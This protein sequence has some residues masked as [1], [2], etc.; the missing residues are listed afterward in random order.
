MASVRP[1]VVPR[2]AR[3]TWRPVTRAPARSVHVGQL[4]G[5]TKRFVSHEPRHSR[6][7][8]GPPAAGEVGPVATGSG[9]RTL[10]DK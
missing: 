4:V 7:D 1:S 5:V 2:P 8:R 9:S 3:R 6:V 10:E